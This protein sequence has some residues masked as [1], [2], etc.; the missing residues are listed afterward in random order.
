MSVRFRL[1]SIHFVLFVSNDGF[2]LVF[3]YL[4]HMLVAHFCSFLFVVYG[5]GVHPMS[6]V[7]VSVQVIVIVF[8]L[9]ANPLCC[10][11]WFIGFQ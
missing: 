6:V 9:S 5:F 8:V 10:V 3:L 7:S 2:G 1:L 4:L 11:F